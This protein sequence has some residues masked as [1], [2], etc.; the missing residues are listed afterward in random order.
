MTEKEFIEKWV[1]KI[2]SELKS[3]PDDFVHS[4]EF[5]EVSLPGKILFLNPP[6]FGSYQLSDEA[7]DTF[8]STGDMFR[9]KYVYY[10]NRLKPLGIKIPVDQ[11]R[12]YETVRDYERYL[13][14]FLKEME[15]DFKQ[16][17]Q[18]TKG[19]KIISSQ[20]FSSLNLART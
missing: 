5:E 19:F 20:I 11:L 7:G 1:D 2:K 18:K 4:E 12:T 13:D 17:F 10:A 8:Y 14:G 3:F 16:T 6:L 15:K 9:A